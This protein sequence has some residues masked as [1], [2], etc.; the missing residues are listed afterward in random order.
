MWH[1]ISYDRE[2]FVFKDGGTIGLDWGFKRPPVNDFTDNNPILVI[3]PGFTSDGNDD[4]SCV[5]P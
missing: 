2:F 1:P 3:V 4:P 5:V